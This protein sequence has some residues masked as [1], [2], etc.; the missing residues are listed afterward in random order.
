MRFLTYEIPGQFVYSFVVELTR[1]DVF[2]ARMSDT[3][4]IASHLLE[5]EGFRSI[6]EFVRALLTLVESIE[7]EEGPWANQL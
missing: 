6:S 3:D 2:K 1:E 7:A 4:S 5:G